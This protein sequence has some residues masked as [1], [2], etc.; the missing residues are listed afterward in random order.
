MARVLV[1]TVKPWNLEHYRSWADATKHESRLIARPEDL[2]ASALA[3]FSPDYVFLP[4]W[5]WRIPA[6]IHERF[7]CVAFHM[8]DLPFGRGGSP[9]QNLIVRG[10]TATQLSAF[11]VSEALD[12]GP[13]Y[14]KRPLTLDGS[15]REIYERAAALAFSMIDE[16]VATRP[17]P[18]AQ[19]GRVV[20][21]ARRT[22]ADS[23]IPVGLDP[24]RL[25]DFIRMLD[26]ETY[27]PAFLV[28]DGLRYE[29]TNASL[30]EGRVVATV[31]VAEKA[32][33]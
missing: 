21:F 2:T 27:P 13:V 18:V 8:T 31:T 9:L 16:I 24:E 19:E 12:A 28:R 25:Y 10:I 3:D 4:H 11:R 7:E 6:E 33:A 20:T 23:E 5:S 14:L 1:A 22:P 17:H 32:L 15:A 29:F 30:R 26:A